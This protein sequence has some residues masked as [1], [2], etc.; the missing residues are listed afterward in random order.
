MGTPS[1]IILNEGLTHSNMHKPLAGWFLKDA[2]IYVHT[3][4]MNMHIVSRTPESSLQLW[5]RQHQPLAMNPSLRLLSPQIS[6][7]CDWF[8]YK[9][10]HKVSILFVQ[11]LWFN[12]MFSDSSML[13]CIWITCFFSLLTGIPLYEC[14]PTDRFFYC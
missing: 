14:I 8:S 12:V 2:Y 13:W 7:A 3:T 6:F 1:F 10:N 4:Q 11:L 9:W 5:T